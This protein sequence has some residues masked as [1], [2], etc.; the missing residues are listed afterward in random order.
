MDFQEAKRRYLASAGV[1]DRLLEA[2]KHGMPEGL[3]TK[4]DHLKMVMDD[5]SVLL[6][7]TPSPY[8]EVFAVCLLRYFLDLGR[9]V[10][11]FD[12]TALRDY[13]EQLAGVS[14]FIGSR[15]LPST[16]Y[17]VQKT[18]ARVRRTVTEGQLFLLEAPSEQSIEDTFKKEFMDYISHVVI[19]VDLSVERKPT[20][21]L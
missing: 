21:R 1:P 19:G 17:M 18:A 6:L 8:K 2:S 5:K 3:R 20:L 12:V 4:Y 13:P 7:G 9:S 11:F 10:A 15:N 16:S 14:A